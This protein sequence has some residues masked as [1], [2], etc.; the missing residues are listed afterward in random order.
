MLIYYFRED[1]GARNQPADVTTSGGKTT[2]LQI[3][4]AG[5]TEDVIRRRLASFEPFT[6]T[7]EPDEEK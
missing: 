2:Y 6:Y 5:I 1:K 4:G 3:L 7:Q